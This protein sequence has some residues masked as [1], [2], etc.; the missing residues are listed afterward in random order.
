[1]QNHILGY[2]DPGGNPLE[3]FALAY[4]DGVLPDPAA[5]QPEEE[6][7]APDR[8]IIGPYYVDPTPRD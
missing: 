8:S 5:V 3:R 2:P 4:P 7:A 6:H 1:M